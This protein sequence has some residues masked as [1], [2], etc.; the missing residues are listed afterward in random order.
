MTDKAPDLTALT[1]TISAAYF[2]NNNVSLQD[3]PSVINAV[4]AAFAALG[5]APQPAAERLIPAVPI[6]KSVTPDYIVCLEDGK[7]LKMLKRHLQSTYGL[8]PEEYRAK[9]GLPPEYPMVA[10]NYA[11]QRSD[12]AKQIGLGR[13]AGRGKAKGKSA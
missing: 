9:W 3:V 7:Q 11:A 8:T 2:E 10:P 13:S 12:L 4:Y 1:A 6:R 5:Q